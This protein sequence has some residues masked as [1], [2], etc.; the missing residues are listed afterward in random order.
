MIKPGPIGA[1]RGQPLSSTGAEQ[2]PPLS[3]SRPGTPEAGPSSASIAGGSLRINK[4]PAPQVPRWPTLS[5]SQKTSGSSNPVLGGQPTQSPVPL[6][7]LPGFNT[8][9]TPRLGITQMVSI[10]PH[11]S[12]L[13]DDIN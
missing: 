3:P 11:S 10:N 6:P 13:I 8:P 7:P 12:C 5:S 9:L 2:P 4:V 1:G